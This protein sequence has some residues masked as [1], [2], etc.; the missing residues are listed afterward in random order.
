M[1]ANP[2]HQQGIQ[3]TNQ[4]HRRHAVEGGDDFLNL[5]GN[6]GMVFHVRLANFTI[7]QQHQGITHDFVFRPEMLK[8]ESQQITQH[9]HQGALAVLA[10]ILITMATVLETQLIDADP[11]QVGDTAEQQ[12]VLSI[13]MWMPGQQL[14]RQFGKRSTSKTISDWY[15]LDLLIRHHNPTHVISS[16]NYTA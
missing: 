8:D 12:A 7:D 1:I 10:T 2:A 15:R 11:A 6:G 9:R 13:K 4:H 14:R 5:A 3:F 16:R